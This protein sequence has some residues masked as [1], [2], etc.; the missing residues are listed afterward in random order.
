[1]LFRLGRQSTAVTALFT[2]GVF[3]YSQDFDK[4]LE[5]KVN[6]LIEKNGSGTDQ[7]LRLRLIAMGRRDQA[8]RTQEYFS[9]KA[10]A[11]LVQKQERV[12]GELTAELKQIVAEKGRPVIALVGLQASEEAALVLTHSRDH[13]FQRQLVPQLQQLAVDG[14]I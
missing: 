9:D 6:R 1:M 13:G 2:A 12:D 3:L 4:E 8:V 11:H 5:A 7:A 10:S 14:K